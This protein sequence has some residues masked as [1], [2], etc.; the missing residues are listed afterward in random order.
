[1]TPYMVMAVVS[2][3]SIFDFLTFLCLPPCTLISQCSIPTGCLLG[4]SGPLPNQLQLLSRVRSHAA[5]C[6]LRNE[7][8][9]ANPEWTRHDVCSKMQGRHF[10]VP[11]SSENQELK[12]IQ[13]G[14][15][16][17]NSF[18]GA[19]ITFA[20]HHLVPHC[21]ASLMR[22]RCLPSTR[23]EE[24][25]KSEAKSSVF[26]DEGCECHVVCVPSTVSV[27]CDCFSPWRLRK[28]ITFSN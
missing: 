18:F 27:V 19:V 5:K 20:T 11:N 12:E 1:M 25:L 21:C 8:G 16:F 24:P 6:S 15:R 14:L 26:D 2:G 9:R 7:G 22:A 4:T 17:K 28:K 3:S 23:R 13:S 10:R